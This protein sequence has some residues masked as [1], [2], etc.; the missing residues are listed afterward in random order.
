MTGFI[1]LNFIDRKGLQVQ[2]IAL[3][4]RTMLGSS[5]PVASVDT[6]RRMLVYL[7]STPEQLAAFDQ[8]YRRCGQGTARI[9]LQSPVVGTCCGYA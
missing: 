1:H 6:L 4:C 8:S 7:G 3:D 9:T 2:A 5:V